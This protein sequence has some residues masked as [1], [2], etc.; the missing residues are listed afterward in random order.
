MLKFTFSNLPTKK[1]NGTRNNITNMNARNGKNPSKKG[2]NTIND[3]PPWGKRGGF[4]HA[5]FVS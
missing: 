4:P 1:H 2:G 5:T 3:N